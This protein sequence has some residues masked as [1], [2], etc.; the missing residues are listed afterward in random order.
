MIALIETI[1]TGLRQMSNLYISL[2]E[3]WSASSGSEHGMVEGRDYALTGAEGRL[4][5]ARGLASAEWYS[6]PI[7]RKRMKELM[8]RSDQPALRDT[9]IWLG[10]MALCGGL[11]VWF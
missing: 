6:S 10:A 8:Q 4:A 5:V 9:A 2:S 3:G 7:P 11:G 1:I